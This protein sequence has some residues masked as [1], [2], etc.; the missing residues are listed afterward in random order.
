LSSRLHPWQK[1]QRIVAPD[2]ANVEFVNPQTGIRSGKRRDGTTWTAP[3]DKAYD[4]GQ[5]TMFDVPPRAQKNLDE[6]THLT[7]FAISTSPFLATCV[8][9][10]A[11]AF[12]HL[13]GIRC[14]DIAVT[15]TPAVRNG[16]M[17]SRIFRN[18]VGTNDERLGQN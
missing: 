8:R 15:W 11:A 13:K 17:R 2:G 16:A 1:L 7:V 12:D 3:P 4:P 18:V 5:P 6:L 14:H 10:I 9:G